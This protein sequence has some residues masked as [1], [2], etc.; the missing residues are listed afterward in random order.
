MS[1]KET[2]LKE[3]QQ[4]EIPQHIAIIMD[5]NG[6]WAKKRGMPRIY[7][8]RA[9]TQS[10][11]EVV[12]A[13]GELKIKILTLYT[14]STENWSRPL[15]E[16]NALMGLLCTMLKREVAELDK[17]GVSLESIGRTEEL[18]EKVQKELK[19]AKEKLR[20]NRGKGLLLN[21]ALNYG[22]RQE[23]LDAANQIL[24]SGLK[25]VDE[26]KFREFLYTGPMA[27]PDLVIRTSGEERLSNFLIFQ[28]AYAEFY[29]TKVLWPDFR[30][31]QLYDA[32]ADYQNR[33]RR[34]GKA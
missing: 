26:I 12:K 22:G 18:S 28:A 8:H 31:E 11:K 25:T 17:S 19:I 16:V 13:C 27:D 20:H 3:I 32:I 2:L 1:S 21:L 6:R 24:K 34:F 7:G 15:T 10:V 23:I 30:K 14:F 9:G 5:G 33:E 29:V 4:K